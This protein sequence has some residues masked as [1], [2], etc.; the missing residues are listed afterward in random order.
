MTSKTI[1][2]FATPSGRIIAAGV[3]RHLSPEETGR[4]SWLF[5]NAILLGTDTVSGTFTGPRREMITPWST[6][7]V[8]I[9][10]NM[11]I[12]GITRI[13]EYAPAAGENPDHDPM[14]QRVYHGLDQEIFTVH[15]EPEPVREIDDIAA[16]NAQE[17]LA[18]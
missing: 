9:T 18:L 13:E 2:F 10:Q 6:N 14:L 3:D 16:Y 5:S 4:L 11:A 7:A 12:T 1:L 17:G 15:H 8:E